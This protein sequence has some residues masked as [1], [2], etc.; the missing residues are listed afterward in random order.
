M[1]A[2]QDIA[3]INARLVDPASGMDAPGALLVRGGRIADIGPRL[4]NDGK[5][6]DASVIDCKGHVLAPGLIDMRVFVGEPGAEHRETI[7]SAGEA[8]AAGGVTTMVLMPST[9]PVIDDAALVAFMR[10]QPCRVNVRPMAALTKGRKGEVMSEMVLL[11]EAGAV[12]FTD[13]DRTLAD[14][15]VM[16]RALSYA[17]TFDLLVVGHCEEPSLSQGAAATEGEIATR[18]GL[19]GVPAIAETI[20]VERDLRLVE[21]TGARYHFGQVTTQS[22]LEAI[23]KAKARGLPVT[24]AVPATHLALNELDIA[25]Y[26]TFRKFSPPLRSEDDRR[27]CVEGLAAGIID[28]IVSSHDPQAPDT[29]RLPFAQAAAGGV[30]LETLLPITLEMVHAKHLTLLEAMRRLTSAPAE[31]LRLPDGV[32]TLSPGAVA[33]LVCLDPDLAIVVDGDKL[34]SR[35]KNTPFDGRRTQGRVM[36]TW[37]KGV[38]VYDATTKV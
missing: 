32:G 10:N 17:A 4:F 18:L 13:A 33:D 16:R 34:R 15:R 11:S 12:G 3:F 26:L 2:P 19:A 31:T 30:G 21:L 23:A 20:I 8:A 22:A 27:A 7:E 38:C 6:R 24:C 29:K 36:Q 9:D 1:T 37:V 28:V 25:G 35:A 5:P 14:A